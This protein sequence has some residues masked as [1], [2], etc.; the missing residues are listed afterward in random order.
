MWPGGE[1]NNAIGVNAK[2]SALWAAMMFLYVYADVL[3]LYRPGQVD[4]ISSG[5]MGPFEVSQGSLLMASVIV[6]IPALMIFL[7]LVLNNTVNRWSNLVAGGL[8][9]LV[10]VS[11]LLGETWAYY[12]IFGILEIAITLLIIWYA[13]LWPRGAA[14][15]AGEYGLA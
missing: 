5:M 15:Q 1:M 7:S 14:A 13:W 6:I 12:L 3:S 11:N 8:F 9:T 2:L 4:E 10:N